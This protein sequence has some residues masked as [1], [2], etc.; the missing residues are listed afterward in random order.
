MVK[1]FSALA[2]LAL[3]GST[4]A[5]DKKAP[6]LSGKWVRDADDFKLSFSFEKDSKMVLNVMA[7]EAGLTVTT[8]YTVDKDGKITAEITDVKE[9][10]NFPTKPETGTKF[11]F[12]FKVDGKSAKLTDFEHPDGDGAKGIIEG[13][14]K[15][16]VD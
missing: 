1:L 2:V 5:E 7:G 14:Y 3:V 11:S 12:K 13:E 16:K 15:K 4:F 10:G 8:K 9:K 6:A